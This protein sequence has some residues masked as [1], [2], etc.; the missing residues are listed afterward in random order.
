MFRSSKNILPGWLAFA[1]TIA[2]V[3]SGIAVLIFAFLTVQVIAQRPVNPYEDTT[4]QVAS[5]NLDYDQTGPAA[6]PTMPVGLPTP[7][8]MPTNQPW[9]GSER[10]N[11]LMMGIDRRPGEAFIS[12]T[13]SMM[14]VSIDPATEAISILSIPRDLYVTI[15][16]RGQDRINTA[17]V[18]GSQG[19][20]PLGGAALAMQAVEYNL[21]VPVHHY[22]MVDFNAVTR[23]V[24]ALGGI[25]LNVPYTINDPTY[26]DMN[27]GYDPVYIPAGQHHMDGSLALKY[28]RTRHGD[29]DIH[30][31]R[32]QQQVVLAVRSKALSLGVG[33][34]LKRA[35]ILYQ[36][37][38]SG[39][40]T[41]FSL[42]QLIKL[43]TLISAIPTENI[44]NEVLGF[45][46]VS[47]YR[48]PQGASVLVLNNQAATPLIDS[49]F[50]DT[51]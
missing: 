16:T 36:Q 4:V 8:L 7:T 13:D 45:E 21:G 5:V 47:S 48:T 31:A 23:G 1:L 18:Y 34:M 37:L 43:G 19:N 20:N 9:Q 30:R 15:P 3:L 41:D 39:V 49:L 50:R 22:V 38:E 12:R 25:D 28:A 17:F 29:S 51:D 27:Y 46:Y 10:V 26:P 11:I 40:M 6:V 32:R 24:D 33:E 35:P 2:F 42:D 14:L 44:H